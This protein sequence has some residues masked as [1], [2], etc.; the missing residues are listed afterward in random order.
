MLHGC[1]ITHFSGLFL[2]TALPEASSFGTQGFFQRCAQ[3]AS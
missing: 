1:S 3:I 2:D